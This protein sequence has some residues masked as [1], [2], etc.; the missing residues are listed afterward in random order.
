MLYV[1]GA[2]FFKSEMRL[3]VPPNDISLLRHDDNDKIT[4]LKAELNVQVPVICYMV[5]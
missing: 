1:Y 4:M 2:R 3:N 5:R